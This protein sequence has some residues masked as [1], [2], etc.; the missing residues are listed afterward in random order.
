M[1]GRS[2]E[3]IIY[4]TGY[5]FPEMHESLLLL[6]HTYKLSVQDEVSLF[7]HR[8]LRSP[9]LQTLQCHLS[10]SLPP[11]LFWS[12]ILSLSDTIYA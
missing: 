5:S 8:A 9:L 3:S 10:S 11:S 6:Q 12:F 2:G 7:K 4:P 1:Y